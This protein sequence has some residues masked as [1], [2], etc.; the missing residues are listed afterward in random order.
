MKH[1]CWLTF[2]VMG[3]CVAMAQPG[4]G[5]PDSVIEPLHSF[6]E[7]ASLFTN[8]SAVTRE[9]N[10]VYLQWDVDSAEDG[11]YFIVERSTDGLHFE[12]IS[13]MRR[14]AG[15]THYESTDLAPPN[16]IDYYRVKYAGQKGRTLFSK[17][18]QLSLSGDVD[19]KFYPNPVD[20]LLIIRTEHAIE[21]QVIDAVGGIRLSKRLQSGIQVVNIS[22]LER[23]VYILRVADKESNRVV[24]NQLIK[25]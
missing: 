21:M 3:C 7:G 9:L 14:S 6:S 24:S 16:G 15:T 20:K 22:F 2:M 11:D 5:T 23:G 19:F 13:V 12:T 1:V 18:M 17:T 25:N 8:F 10:R 4:R